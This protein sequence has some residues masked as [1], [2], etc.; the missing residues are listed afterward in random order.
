MKNLPRHAA[1]VAAVLTAATGL[2]LP[3]TA[4][5]A[6][7]SYPCPRVQA[8]CV[9]TEPGGHGDLRLLWAEE[10]YI[11]PPVRSAQN[12]TPEPW[13]FFNAPGYQGDERREVT[14]NETVADFGFD[15]LSARQGPC[16][17]Q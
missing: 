1:M 8:V 15:A 2:A 10:P 7:E 12:Q 6:A 17:W 16:Q 5:H 9:W 3:T 13:C 11:V 14:H 4:A